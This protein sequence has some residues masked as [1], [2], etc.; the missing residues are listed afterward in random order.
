MDDTVLEA[1]SI[2]ELNESVEI[3]VQS[4][5]AAGFEINPSKCALMSLGAESKSI[6][7]GEVKVE[8]RIFLFTFH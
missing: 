5:K 8:N 2:S 4:L 1:E 3:T 7:Q 6:K